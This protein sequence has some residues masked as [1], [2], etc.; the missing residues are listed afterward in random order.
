ME[1]FP[2]RAADFSQGCVVRHVSPNVL[3]RQMAAHLDVYITQL[4]HMIRG[5]AAGLNI[6]KP[7][8][9]N[10]LVEFGMV[11]CKPDETDRRSIEF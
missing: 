4:P 3:S 2:N 7:G 9:P 10:R 5:P 6:S 1:I 8:S 11:R